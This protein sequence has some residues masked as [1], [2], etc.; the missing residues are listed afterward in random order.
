[1]PIKNL[2]FY[3]GGIKGVSY[4]GALFYLENYNLLPE[5][6]RVC[7][8]SIGSII[9]Y[10]YAIGCDGLEIF[11]FI[12]REEF[13]LGMPNLM[14]I[15][16]NQGVFDT[17]V[18]SR[19]LEKVSMNKFDCIPT[20]EK[21][22]RKSGIDLEVIAYDLDARRSTSFSY[23]TH[24]DMHVIT[25]IGYSISIP[26]L[27]TRKYYNGH[28]L[29]D[30]GV[31]LRDVLDKYPAEESL[32]LRTRNDLLRDTDMISYA[33]NIIQILMEEQHILLDQCYSHPAITIDCPY[34]STLGMEL[35]KKERIRMF[36]IGYLSAKKYATKTP[37]V[38][39]H[40]SL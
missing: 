40:D 14:D 2:I 22:Y 32:I 11:L 4:T 35:T 24:P 31:S 8:I 17:E 27:M 23:H 16:T 18:V 21:L 1:M 26:I 15:V 30:G 29:I 39:S 28:T 37:K 36:V 13:K 33:L 10:L 25:A 34:N 38:F 7:G 9:G 12:N 20:F 3:P 19:F 5:V 6:E